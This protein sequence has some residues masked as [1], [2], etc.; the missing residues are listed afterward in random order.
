MRSLAWSGTVRHMQDDHESHPYPFRPDQPRHVQI[1]SVLL[2]RIRTGQLLP[3]N[4]LPSEPRLQR[5][6]GVARDTVRKAIVILREDGYVTTV[7]GMGTFVTD[8]DQ[9]PVPLAASWAAS[10]NAPG[11]SSA[12]ASA[13]PSRGSWE[14]SANAPGRSSVMASVRPSRGSWATIRHR[15]WPGHPPWHRP[16]R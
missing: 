1:A 15:T 14:P 8:P 7:Q 4:P 10:A 2:N 5:E 16:G 6:F 12:M 3:R 13:R 9:W 11:R